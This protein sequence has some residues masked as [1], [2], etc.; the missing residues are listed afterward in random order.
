MEQQRILVVEDDGVARLKLELQLQHM[1]HGVM[2]VASGAAGIDLMMKQRFDLMITDLCLPDIDGI[3]VMQEAHKVDPDITVIILTGAASLNSAIA[4]TNNQAFRYLLKPVRSD[5]LSRN[6]IDAISHR[7]RIA[8]RTQRY[9][10]DH[11]KRIGDH[12]LQIGP[13]LIDPSR[14]RVLCYGRAITL[15]RSEF[16][17][18]LYLARRRGTVVPIE[19]IAHTVLGYQCSPQEA[20][21]LVR[22][23]IHSLRLKIEGPP[24]APRLIRSVRGIGYR[25]AEDDEL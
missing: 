14:H 24:H 20:R 11:A 10:P 25:L 19:E 23:R 6:V 4:A 2:S 3:Q 8:E 17:L 5:E 9:Y 16:S 22:N 15:S 13:L 7:R 1:G 18:L 12:T 21:H